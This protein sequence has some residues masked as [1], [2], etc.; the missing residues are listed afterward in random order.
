MTY[1]DA[2]GNECDLPTL[3]VREPGWATSRIERLTKENERLKSRLSLHET[4]PDRWPCSRC[5]AYDSTLVQCDCPKQY[6]QNQEL[7]RL[8][9]ERDELRAELEDF[10]GSH[11][12]TIR[13]D[14]RHMLEIADL[15][16]E[17]ERLREALGNAA[18]VAAEEVSGDYG[19]DCA[20][21]VFHAVK[22]HYRVITGC[23]CAE[24]SGRNCP[25][26]QNGGG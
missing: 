16:A 1:H 6:K 24:T 13:A 15:R 5:T 10:K 14:E 23:A 17:V 26:H 12:I 19:K 3:V 25:V 20:Q 4:D 21:R 9:K 18:K 11:D 2:D 8:T 22:W 7:A